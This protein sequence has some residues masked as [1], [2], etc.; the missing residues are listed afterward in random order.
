MSL[1]DKKILE[2]ENKG[3][4]TMSTLH[5]RS[6]ALTCGGEGC[7]GSPVFG[8]KRGKALFKLYLTPS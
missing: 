1:G 2:K 5:P 3:M 8:R 6:L 4:I 7:H